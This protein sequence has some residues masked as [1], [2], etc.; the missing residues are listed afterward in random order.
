MEARPVAP[1][2][3]PIDREAEEIPAMGEAVSLVKILSD[4]REKKYEKAQARRA[5]RR[6]KREQLRA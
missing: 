6:R 2:R 5:A 1:P 4:R 3:P